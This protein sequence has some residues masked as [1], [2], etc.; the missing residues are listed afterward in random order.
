MAIDPG[1][2]GGIAWKTPKGSVRAAK[3]PDNVVDEIKLLHEEHCIDIV[4]IEKVSMW[5]SGNEDESPGRAMQMQKLFNSQAKIVGGLSALG[6]PVVEVAPIT[7]QAYCKLRLKNDKRSKADRKKDYKNF[8]QR[9]TP[10][11]KVNLN[12]ADAICMLAY[13][14]LRDKNEP[15]Y[16]DQYIKQTNKLF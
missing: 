15:G 7:W 3:M 4:V 13:V 12:T 9:Q 6:I 11:L 1:V 2:S 16:F 5:R 10:H 14:A 8:A